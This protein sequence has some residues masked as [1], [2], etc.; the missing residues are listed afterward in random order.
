MSS[1][2]DRIIDKIEF[3]NPK[4]AV[5]IRKT[6]NELGEDLTYKANSF[7]E[8]Y[9]DYLER[10]NKTIE[11]GVKCYLQMIDDMFEERIQF[12]REGKYSSS[13]FDEVEKRVY[14]NPAIM[15]Y[16]MHGLALAQFLWYEQFQRFS[17]FSQNLRKHI[18]ATNKY[19]E[20][21]GGHGL[22]IKEA[23]ETIPE[24]KQ[25]DLVDISQSSIDLAKGI[26]NN[27]R[28]N[29]YFKNIYDFNEDEYSYDFITMGEVLEHVEDPLSLLIKIGKLLVSN[30]VCFITTPI[31][32]PMIDHI[33]LFNDEAEIRELLNL[34]NLKILE[35]RIV[36]SDNE[37]LN[38]AKKYKSPV[39]YAA[40]VKLN[41]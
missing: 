24:I 37:T 13:S 27:E 21:G 33:Y 25:F 31:N 34:A 30:G 39:M 14:A 1:T 35:E 28:V 9:I 12:I 8:K 6:L 20:I 7:Y 5:K 11:F 22:Y 15:T 4:H 38:Y 18:T 41:N 29:Y 10:E 36:I 3:A 16:H 40:F 23:V 17:F 32:S 19:L 2:I 26:L